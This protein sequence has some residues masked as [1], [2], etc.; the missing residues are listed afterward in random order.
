MSKDTKGAKGD[1]QST[2]APKDGKDTKG[3]KGQTTILC[4]KQKIEQRYQRGKRSNN[5]LQSTIR[6]QKIEQRY[7]RGKRSNNDLQ[8]YENKRSSKDTKGAK[9]Q[10]TI[11]KALCRNQKIEQRYQ[12]GKITNNDLLFSENKDRAKIPKGRSNN[13]LQSTMQ[14]TKDRAKIP[15][16]QKVKQRS[17]KHYAEN[18]SEQRYCG[19]FCQK[20]RS[21]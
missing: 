8:S 4:R 16:G 7:Q 2:I 21:V 13:D 9:G 11:Y 1:L 14:K 5:D 19:I 12:R 3:A 17:T 10:T 20:D 15:K 6:K 18:K